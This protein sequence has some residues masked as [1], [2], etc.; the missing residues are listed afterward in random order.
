M[1]TSDHGANK[2]LT[3]R[4][5]KLIS[6]KVKTEADANLKRHGLSISQLRVIRFILSCDGKCT[7][8]QIENHLQVS[9]PT[10]VG[11]VSRLEQGGFVVISVDDSDRRNRVVAT[12]P[13]AEAKSKE[14][15][16]F[17]DNVHE[18]MFGGLTDDELSALDDYLRRVYANLYK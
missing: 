2:H 7:Q 8:K 5:I 16:E 14:L 13:K 3:G 6:D 9:H 17:M 1:S 11:I 12:T 15:C 4:L 10:V 18:K